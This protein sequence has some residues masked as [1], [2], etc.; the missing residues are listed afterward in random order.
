M[1]QGKTV[2]LVEDDADNQ[3]IY[4][5]ILNH[6]GYTVLQAPDGE[7]GVQMARDHLPDLILMDLTMPRV[8]GLQATRMLKADSA[9]HGIPVVALTAHGEPEDRQAAHDAGCVAFLA[10]PVE[11]RRVAAE[12]GRILGLPSSAG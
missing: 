7:R 8:D 10:K 2:L 6:H 11:P 3:M 12:V 5:M 1:T 9:T 4:S